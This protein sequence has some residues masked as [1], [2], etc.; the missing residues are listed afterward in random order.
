[1]AAKLNLDFLRRAYFTFDKPVPYKVDDVGLLIKPVLLPD[2]EIFM[3]SVDIL[4]YDKNSSPDVDI[5]QMSYLEY[6]ARYIAE[7]DELTAAKLT[8]I[9]HLCMDMTA[10]HI[11]ENERGKA[12]LVDDT[13][14]VTITAKK[15]DDISRIILYQNILHYDDEYVNPELRKMMNE[16]DS[17]KNFGKEFPTLERKMNII[18]AHTGI[19]KQQQMA[20]TMREHQGVFEEVTG[21]VEFL[22]TRA[23]ALYC[24]DKKAEHWIYRNKKGKYDGYMTSMGAYKQSFG[25]DGSITNVAQGDGTS[26][27]EQL[28]NK[29]NL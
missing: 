18:T 2:A 23:L 20:M 12:I 5:I 16:V 6:M 14:G 10:W 26:H 29:Y 15:F 7:I 9:L 28:L 17:V 19:T 25:G 21:E 11:G 3:S 27:A 22:T 13:H 1:M 8:N 24:G 4:Q